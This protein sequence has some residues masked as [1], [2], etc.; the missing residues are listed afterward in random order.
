MGVRSHLIRRFDGFRPFAGLGGGPAGASPVMSP[1]S[2]RYSGL[3]IVLQGVSGTSLAP[4]LEPI[5][6]FAYS[7][8]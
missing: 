6:S 1:L 2:R 3:R 8:E 7:C 5:R 4:P